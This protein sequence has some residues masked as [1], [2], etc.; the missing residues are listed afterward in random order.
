[1]LYHEIAIQEGAT[2]KVGIVGK[3]PK[4]ALGLRHVAEFVLRGSCHD[5]LAGKVP[6]VVWELFLNTEPLS[7]FLSEFFKPCKTPL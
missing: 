4:G 1:M 6:L 7:V 3:G 5:S 2:E